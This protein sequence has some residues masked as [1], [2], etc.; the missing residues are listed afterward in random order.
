MLQRLPHPSGL[1]LLSHQRNHHQGEEAERNR[2]DPRLTPRMPTRPAGSDDG[3][4]DGTGIDSLVAGLGCR[5]RGPAASGHRGNRPTAD[6]DDVDF[7]FRAG[8][9]QVVSLEG[10]A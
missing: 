8:F 1:L 4:D 9:V 6:I 3:P 2:A 5:E 10:E 7:V